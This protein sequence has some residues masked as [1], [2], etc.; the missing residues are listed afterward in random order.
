[1]NQLHFKAKQP[2]STFIEP[3]ETKNNNID[4]SILTQD[5]TQDIHLYTEL[6]KQTLKV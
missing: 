6:K 1:M 4:K 3:N 5:I 2:Q